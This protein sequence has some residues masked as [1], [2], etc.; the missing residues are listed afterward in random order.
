MKEKIRKNHRYYEREIDVTWPEWYNKVPKKQKRHS[1]KPVFDSR[2]LKHIKCKDCGCESY[3]D[4]EFQCYVFCDRF[5]KMTFK[6]PKCKP[7]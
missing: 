5:G 3:Y 4:P 6:R 2:K 7:E 1:W